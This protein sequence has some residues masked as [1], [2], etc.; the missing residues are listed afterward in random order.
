MSNV[1]DYERID[2]QDRPST[3]TPLGERNLDKM[4]QAIYDI[5]TYLN[6]EGEFILQSSSWSASGSPIYPYKLF[7]SDERY[8]DNDKPFGQV[9]GINE[10]ETQ[11]E[12]ESIGYIKKITVD[13]TGITVYATSAP[14]VNLKLIL[15]M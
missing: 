5:A 3:Q 9:W 4:D 13:H 12:I 14:T 7:I 2:F 10:I 11:D 15:K 6:K 8:G 1:I